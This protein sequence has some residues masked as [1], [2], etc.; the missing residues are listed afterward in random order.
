MKRQYF[1]PDGV[2][3]REPTQAE[4]DFEWDMKKN[5]PDFKMM[6]DTIAELVGKTPEEVEA[7]MKK[8]YKG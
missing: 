7:T 1:T 4:L 3:E 5:G 6:K 2:I 8:H